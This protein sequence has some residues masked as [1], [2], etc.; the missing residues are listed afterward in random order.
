MQGL[1]SAKH[2]AEESQCHLPSA[3]M[4]FCLTQSAH[5]WRLIRSNLW[6]DTSAETLVCVWLLLSELCVDWFCFE[7]HTCN[8]KSSSND[9]DFFYRQ[10]TH[11]HT[12]TS[13]EYT[14]CIAINIYHHVNCV[15]HAWKSSN[16]PPDTHIGF[17][18]DVSCT[19]GFFGVYVYVHVREMSVSCLC[20]ILWCSHF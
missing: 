11:T 5:A 1:N 19:W 3:T 20:F 9:C 18:S 16:T 12:H 4:S 14:S 13:D 15:Q 2:S 10:N 6:Q 8:Y 17:I 7:F